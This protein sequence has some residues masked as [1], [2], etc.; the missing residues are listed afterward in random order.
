MLESLHTCPSGQAILFVYREKLASAMND[1]NGLNKSTLKH[2]MLARLNLLVN[3][4][5]ESRDLRSRLS[6]TRSELQRVEHEIFQI[7]CALDE[8]TLIAFPQIETPQPTRIIG[9]WGSVKYVNPSNDRAADH[10]EA[11]DADTSHI[12]ERRPKSA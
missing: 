2:A 6:S 4:R 7:Q 10:Q 5:C 8:N 11:P 9:R 3:L 12:D 1:F